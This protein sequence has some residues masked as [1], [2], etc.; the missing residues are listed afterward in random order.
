MVILL[1]QR[2]QMMAEQLEHHLQQQ[3][4]HMQQ[5][6]HQMQQQM[7][8]M[9]QQMIQMQQ[10]LVAHDTFNTAT[11]AEIT[12]MNHYLKT[13]THSTP[14]NVLEMSSRISVLEQKIEEVQVI[15]SKDQATPKPKAIPDSLL[16][17]EEMILR[18]GLHLSHVPLPRPRARDQKLILEFNFSLSI[19]L[20]SQRLFA[21]TP[22]DFSGVGP[23]TGSAPDGT[24][25][26]G[27]PRLSGFPSID[28][29]PSRDHSRNPSAKNISLHFRYLSHFFFFHDSIRLLNYLR[30]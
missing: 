15:Q 29:N 18:T 1:T 26:P 30:E 3:M 24:A 22:S 8:Q 13:H 11:L 12:G 23:C 6:M 2:E 5:Q 10:Q 4:S 27:E 16:G 14:N 20:P 28:C 7:S 21:I 9:H 17:K 19:I 25:A